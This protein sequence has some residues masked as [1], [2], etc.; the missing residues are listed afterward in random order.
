MSSYRADSLIADLR[1]RPVPEEAQ[2]DLKRILAEV[3][4]E[5]VYFCRY[6]PCSAHYR[7]TNPRK[8]FCCERCSDQWWNIY[9]RSARG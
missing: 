1:K 3:G 9:G 5:D 8:V 7:T 4:V 2:S 6:A